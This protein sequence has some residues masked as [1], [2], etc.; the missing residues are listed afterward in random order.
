MQVYKE[1]ARWGSVPA[2]SRFPL[3]KREEERAGH[4]GHAM[5]RPS[6]PGVSKPDSAAAVGSTP[7]VTTLKLKAKCRAGE[8]ERPSSSSHHVLQAEP[9]DRVATQCVPGTADHHNYG[10]PPQ[11]W[12]T[13]RL[14]SWGYSLA[15]KHL[16]VDPWVLI[17][18]M[19]EG[20]DSR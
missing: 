4:A 6:M 14:R 5:Q 3:G 19:E 7:A 12:A 9:T 13:L 8:E 16:R 20:T 1:W 15:T 17:P 11:W 2:S 10:L 18:A